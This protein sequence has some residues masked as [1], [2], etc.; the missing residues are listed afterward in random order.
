ML[1]EEILSQPLLNICNPLK[2]I[3]GSMVS[4]QHLEKQ[5]DMDLKRHVNMFF[6]WWDIQQKNWA[7]LSSKSRKSA[8]IEIVFMS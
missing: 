4:L 2:Y 8:E 3:R 1:L 6:H 7:L 5:T